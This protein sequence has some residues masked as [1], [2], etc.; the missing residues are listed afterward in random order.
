MKRIYIILLLL[1]C[2]VFAGAKTSTKQITDQRGILGGPEYKIPLKYTYNWIEKNYAT[3]EEG[4]AIAV[5]LPNYK[6][7]GVPVSRKISGNFKNGRRSGIWTSTEYTSC[8]SFK[9]T[10]NATGSYIDGVP[11]GKWSID[12]L[13][14]LNGTE[15]GKI[16]CSAN[17]KKGIAVGLFSFSGHN[18]NS[19]LRIVKGQFNNEGFCT[20][21]WS[22]IDQYIEEY[23]YKDGYL[24][25]LKQSEKGSG[26]VLQEERYDLQNLDNYLY[27]LDTT[28]WNIHEINR[29]L[30]SLDVSEDAWL[31]PMP[32]ILNPQIWNL[33]SSYFEAIGGANHEVTSFRVIKRKPKQILALTE[34]VT[35]QYGNSDSW[36]YFNYVFEAGGDMVKVIATTYLANNNG[37]LKA[38]QSINNCAKKLADFIKQNES[39][40]SD[41]KYVIIDNGTLLDANLVK[42]DSVISVL[43][44]AEKKL[45]AEQERLA[46]EK[47]E[48]ERLVQLY[49]SLQVDIIKQN[50]IIES[51]CTGNQLDSSRKSATITPQKEYTDVWQS[52]L[53]IMSSLKINEKSEPTISNIEILQK[54]DNFQKSLMQNVLNN[55]LINDIKKGLEAIYLEAGKEHKDVTE[56]YK[57][58]YVTYDFTPKFKL[59]EE[60]DLYLS[61]LNGMLSN[62]ECCISFIKER[63]LI[64]KANNQIIENSKQLK[65]IT[66]AYKILYESYDLSWNPEEKDCT[67]R[68]QQIIDS[69]NRIMALISSSGSSE[70]DARLKGVKIIE[71]IKP[72][73]DVQ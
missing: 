27:D 63:K 51:V 66:K 21:K 36:P 23:E 59:I 68:L 40:T 45:I 39:K 57:K 71:E 41:S 8:P 46:K 30:Y 16:Q 53:L 33:Q 22:I 9:E 49:N 55:K 43:D 56:A 64:E 7:D 73:L 5:S 69:Q 15:L 14:I 32:S 2:V 13:F 50:Q 6:F 3:I 61:S 62:Q 38:I 54:Y 19:E 35:N 58:Q 26:K 11:D 10:L 67:S 4:L 18:K 24:L 25:S 37:Q 17:F 65:N 34:F 29:Y 52:Y 44:S 70:I 31:Q 72:I 47:A 20:G 42:L 60:Y 1:L 28:T 48:K 12:Y